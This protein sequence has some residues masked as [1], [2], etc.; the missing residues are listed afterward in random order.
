MITDIFSS[1]DPGVYIMGSYP[2]FFWLIVR[3]SL[4]LIR[5]A[6]WISMGR[7]LWSFSVPVDLM[8][9]E[10]IR[11][12]SYHIKGYCSFITPLFIILIIINL[13]GLIPYSFSYSRHMVF[14][15]IL[16]FPLWL[17][18]IISSFRL[19]PG[20]FTA[21][22]LPSGVPGWLAPFLSWVEGVR[23]T[24]RPGTL[25]VRLVANT[26]AGHIVLRIIGI[27]ASCLIF[28]YKT[29]LVSLFLILL[30]AGYILFEVGISFAQAFIFP[31]LG[32]IYT[33][34]HSS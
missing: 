34:E 24:V 1:F 8:C 29:L 31:L 13:M 23:I 33:N 11:S 30:E 6:Y 28:S 26:R 4:S 17:W 20:G 22:I 32:T 27:Y 9:N 15:L 10:S 5:G 16:R 19:S 18:I 12:L 7:F 14:C 21:G 3:I 25:A 2:L